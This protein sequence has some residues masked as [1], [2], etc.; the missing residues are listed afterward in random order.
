MPTGPAKVR[1]LLAGA[2][3]FGREHLAHLSERSD[4]CVAGIADCDPTA[5]AA[6]PG[7]M[8]QVRTERDAFRLIETVDADALIIATPNAT[9]VSLAMAALKRG[10]AVLVEKPVATSAAAAAPLV[11]L[12][13]QTH[14]LLLPGHVLRFSHDHRRLVGTV[15]EGRIGR[16]L[17]VN[18]RRYRDD[19]HAVRYTDTDPVLMTLIHDIDLAVWLTGSPFVRVGAS[20]TGA[21]LRAMTAIG[22]VTEDGVRC[23]LRTA[24]TFGSGAIPADRLE[25]VGDRGSIELNVGEGMVL[26][27]DGRQRALPTAAGTDPLGNELEHFLALVRDRTLAPALTLDDALMGLRLA[28]AAL[29]ALA[30]GREIEIAP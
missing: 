2:G 4:A 19:S 23:D 3:T 8:G 30:A 25:V 13:R 11:E 9:H 24:W 6:L 10:L 12:L 17:Y 20:R 27:I 26:T 5:L 29:A 14:G 16:I 7:P 22:A 18:S 28:D 21:G 15:K 1:V